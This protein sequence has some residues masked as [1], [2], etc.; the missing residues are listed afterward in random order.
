[1]N[2][3]VNGWSRGGFVKAVRHDPDCPDGLPDFRQLIHVAYKV[4]FELG[5]AYIRVWKNSGHRRQE[6]DA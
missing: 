4:A 3:T 2:E 1:V 6:R 5:D